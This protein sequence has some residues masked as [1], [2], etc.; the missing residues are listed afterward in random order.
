MKRIS[1]SE[2]LEI[3]YKNLYEGKLNKIDKNLDALIKAKKMILRE[4][5]KNK[6]L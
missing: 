2:M 6:K 1:D 4:R 5:K 3:C